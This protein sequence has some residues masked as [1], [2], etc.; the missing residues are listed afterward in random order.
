MIVL[1]GSITALALVDGWN[2]DEEIIIG[3]WAM[4]SMSFTILAGVSVLYRIGH[5][6]RAYLLFLFCTFLFC[7]FLAP[8]WTLVLSPAVFFCLY[9]IWSTCEEIHAESF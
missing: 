7:L 3:S 2:S 9:I 4:I 6:L 1:L 5:C 8:C